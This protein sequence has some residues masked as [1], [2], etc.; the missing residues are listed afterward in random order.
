M[1][2]IL[3]LFAF[4]ISFIIM[5][6]IIVSITGYAKDDAFYIISEQL[7]GNTTLAGTGR[8]ITNFVGTMWIVVDGIVGIIGALGMY[9]HLADRILDLF[10]FSF[11]GD[12]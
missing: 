8:G 9:Q 1:K 3:S 11:D 4:V 2:V 12:E 6:M 10:L 5:N 7:S